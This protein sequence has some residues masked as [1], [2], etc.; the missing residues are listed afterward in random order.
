MS[1]SGANV[2][3]IFQ[4]TVICPTPSQVDILVSDDSPAFSPTM[5]E[6]NRIF[7]W[8]ETRPRGYKTWV[9]SKTQNKALLQLVEA[10]QGGG[11]GLPPRSLKIIHWSHQ[12]P[13]NNFLFSLKLFAFAPQIPKNSSASPQIPKNISKFSLKCIFF[14]RIKIT[15]LKTLKLY[16]SAW[17]ND[18]F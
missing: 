18:H 11:E 5:Y 13:E 10:P 3:L 2:L 4:C 17:L 1:K 16:N 15:Y 6:Y 14:P 8:V 12:I 9:K 7:T